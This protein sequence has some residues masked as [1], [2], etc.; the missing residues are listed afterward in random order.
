[1]IPIGYCSPDL[2]CFACFSLNAF[3]TADVGLRWRSVFVL[4]IGEFFFV[5][6]FWLGPVNCSIQILCIFIY[7]LFLDA[8]S[9]TKRIATRPS[10]YAANQCAFAERK[11]AFEANLFVPDIRF[12]FQPKGWFE[13]NGN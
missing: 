6:L 4:E 3:S 2:S 9:Q 10:S 7:D 5:V 12:V 8:A 11:F 13:E 1:V